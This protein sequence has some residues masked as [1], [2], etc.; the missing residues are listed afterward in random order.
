ML[1]AIDGRTKWRRRRHLLPILA[2]AC[3]GLVVA[4][5]TWLVASTWEARLAKVNF[6]NLAGD[7]ASVLQNGLDQYLAK[8]IVMRAFYNSSVEVD[9]EEFEVFTGRILKGTPL[10]ARLSWSP[11]V[12]GAERAAFEA[13]ARDMGLADYRIRD[14]ASDGNYSVA[15]AR[16]DYFPILF[17]TT[18]ISGSHDVLG[19]DLIS[20]PARR[21]AVELARDEDR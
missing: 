12:T 13:K 16:A 17:A 9:K 7:Y 20:E 14:W 18:S 11:R 3:L 8:M 15:S 6:A 4:V 2:V 1:D 5:A 19:V 10:M 21:K